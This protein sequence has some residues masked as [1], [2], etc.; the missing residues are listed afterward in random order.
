MGA[1]G[2]NRSHIV[3]ARRGALG[4][5][6]RPFV[7]EVEEDSNQRA[8]KDEHDEHE[9]PK[10]LVDPV[11]KKSAFPVIATS[12]KKNGYAPSCSLLGRRSRRE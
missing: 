1:S 6:F 10:I 4:L 7:A 11:H 12:K 8:E 9:E 3:E 2:L 5:I